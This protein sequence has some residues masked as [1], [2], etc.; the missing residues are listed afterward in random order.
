[1][2]NLDTLINLMIEH[3]LI[4]HTKTEEGIFYW[5]PI[6]AG[7]NLSQE[8]IESYM[9]IF[10]ASKFNVIANDEVDSLHEMMLC[11]ESSIGA[12]KKK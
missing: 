2:P 11:L 4:A 3:K 5:I 10:G 6:P 12:K 7:V 1:M 9:S 8:Q